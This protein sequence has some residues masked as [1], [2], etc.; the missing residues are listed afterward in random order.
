M[1]SNGKVGGNAGILMRMG[2]DERPVVDSIRRANNALKHHR[3]MVQSLNRVYKA[4]GDDAK[5]L[6]ASYKGL[7]KEIDLMTQKQ[8]LIQRDLAKTTKGT[9]AYE[10]LQTNLQK[11]N[12]QLF[13]LKAR[14]DA[15]AKAM[16]RVNTEGDK[17]RAS[18][19]ATNQLEKQRV[20]LLKLHNK[21]T[22]AAILEQQ[23]YTNAIKQSE[24]IRRTE[25]QTLREMKKQYGASGVAM[26]QQRSKI[27]Q[28]EIEI[29]KYRQAQRQAA[30]A[31]QYMANK[32][33][34][35]QTSLGRTAQL[36]KQNRAFLA[37]LRNGMMS[38][39]AGLT[40][41][42]FPLRRAFTG[43]LGAVVEWEEAF[44]QVRK[45]VN[46]ASEKEFK[47]LDAD[48]MRMSKTI[49]ESATLIAETMGLAA[50]LGVAKENLSGFTEVALQ[51]GVATNMSVDDAASAMA[52]FA[53]VTGMEQ[54]NKNFRKLGSTIVN[55]G[56]NLATQEDEITNYMLRL[57]GT[58]RTVNMAEQ[59]IIALGAAMSSLGINAEAGGSAMSKVMQK[60]N[61]AV[62]DGGE[63]LEEFAKVAGVTGKEFA[64][65]WA[66]DPYKALM[67][68]Q[69]GMKGV[70]DSG[71]NAKKQLEELGIKELRET[72]AVLRLANGYNVMEDAYRHANKGWKE[73]TALSDEAAER[74][75]T[76]GSRIQLF[77]N[78]LFATGRAIG[79][80]L[81]PHL[82]KLMD[83]ITPLL[84]KI[85]ESSDRTKV[86][87]AT[88]AAV[89]IALGPV[90]FV[91]SMLIGSLHSL[92]LGF[93]VLG[94]VL[95]KNPKLMK[96]VTS[97]IVGLSKGSLGGVKSL[98]GLTKASGLLTGGV[99]LLGVAFRFLTGPIGLAI[100]AV[101]ILSKQFVKIYKEVDWAR[102][103]MQ[104]LGSFIVKSLKGAFDAALA[105]IKK[106][107]KG[108]Q[109]LK[110]VIGNFV[111]D[112][113][114]KL[115]KTKFGKFFKDNFKE[116]NEEIRKGKKPMDVL[117]DGVSENTKK[118]LGKYTELVQKSTKKM[119]ELRHGVLSEEDR[120]TIDQYNFYEKRGVEIPK[121]V[122]DAHDKVMEKYGKHAKELSVIYTTMAN[123]SLT[124]LDNKHKDEKTN[125][126]EFF[127]STKAL[128]EKE[129]KEIEKNLQTRQNKQKVET[130][131]LFDEI[132]AIHKKGMAERGYLTDDELKRIE[133]LEVL[134]S[135]KTVQNLA[136]SAQEQEII[137]SRMATNKV[138]V[139][140]EAVEKIVADSE[141]AKDKV[142]KAAE[143]QRDGVIQQAME[144]FEAGTIS[145]EQRD[146]VSK[147]AED[148]YKGV[149]KEADKKHKDVIRIASEQAAE[150]G[151]V[152][153]T[154]TGE[155]LSKWEV[156]WKNTKDG[157]KNFFTGLWYDIKEGWE[158]IKLSAKEFGLSLL[159]L[160]SA[161]SQK[162]TNSV[163]T[164]FT[165]LWEDITRWFTN[166][167]DWVVN[168]FTALGQ[169]I[170]NA[171]KAVWTFIEPAVKLFFKGFE[172]YFK[173]LKYVVEFVFRGI[174]FIIKEVVGFIVGF[175]IEGFSRMY[176]NVKL[177][178][179]LLYTAIKG[180]FNWIKESVMSIVTPTVE[181]VVEKYRWLRNKSN[182]IFT[183]IH[184]FVIGIYTKIKTK[185]SEIVSSIVSFVTNKFN[186]MKTL[187]STIVTTIYTVVRD[188]FINLRDRVLAIVSPFVQKVVG[189]FNLLK[190]K[191]NYVMGI[192]REVITSIWTSIR[193][194]VVGTVTGLR[195]RVVGIFNALKNKVTG[196]VNDTKN[197]VTGGFSEARKTTETILDKMR[198]KVLSIFD[199]IKN[200]ISERIE[201]IKEFIDDLSS[202]VKKSINVVVDGINWV[203]KKIGMSTE[204]PHLHTGTT[205]T[206]DYVTN[207]RINRDTL[208]VVGDR[209]HGNGPNGFRHEMIED[210]KGNLSLTPAEDTVVPLKKGYRV[211]SGKVTHDYLKNK[212]GELPKF[213]S[214]TS[215]G[216]GGLGSWIKS[217]Y[218]KVKDTVGDVMD[219]VK[220]PR[221]L[222]N[223]VLD[224]FGFDNFSTLGGIPKDFAKSGF[225]LLKDKITE[226]FKSALETAE[227]NG[228]Y[229][230]LKKGINFGFA[231]SA[232]AARAAGYPFASPHYGLDLN[233]VYD[234]LYSTIGGTATAKHD[235]SGFGKHIWIKAAKGLE[236]IYGHLSK[237]AFYGTKRV[238]AGDYLGVSGNTGR[239]TGPHLHYEMRKN[240]VPFDPLPWLKNNSK[241]T[242]TA[243]SGVKGLWGGGGDHDHNHD[244]N[245]KEY[246]LL[247]EKVKSSPVTLTMSE[248]DKYSHNR[249]ANY[250][251]PQDRLLAMMNKAINKFNPKNLNSYANGGLV[252]RHQIAE[253]GERNKPE[254]IIPLTKKARA[255][256]LIELAKR[257]VGIDS[258]GN[259]EI[260]NNTVISQGID[261][262]E[263]LDRIE[264]T[265]SQLS[266]AILILAQA[267]VS[268]QIDG[269]EVAKQTYKDINKFSENN[270]RRINK[271]RRD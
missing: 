97:A 198:N 203:G 183:V 98:L 74:Y 256:Q 153:D 270:E 95:K 138:A 194:K 177:T 143:E 36:L 152:V 141:D 258:D 218:G 89:G 9:Q 237:F 86:L 235:N 180:A 133:E 16:S 91:G 49:P 264:N 241:G 227:G 142:I 82:I 135:E 40:I 271:Y 92:S 4:Q 26:D 50:Q 206:T 139:D 170:S 63:D 263:R 187:L 103:A 243:G 10:R 3:S 257:L 18:F 2:I 54:T 145:E 189:L 39:G 174:Y 200:G 196:R 119:T 22:D 73:G 85:Q 168:F 84:K 231:P 261:Y 249:K 162:V 208:A 210:T 216:A 15:V 186:Y 179:S 245:P 134:A 217:T 250:D 72:D 8:R 220:S 75:A 253:I 165:G 125:L 260:E 176:N 154:E 94:G 130:Q 114:E 268:V 68:F 159:V 255:G 78:E 129:Q 136:S 193:T 123:E 238:K 93:S 61:N 110:N 124:Q 147:A 214:G 1:A 120:I 70:I 251:D 221:K 104:N 105:D 178:V 121:K 111:E 34:I 67:L 79:E 14:Q 81:A 24:K 127:K 99:R 155:I 56:N 59:N 240:G 269:R 48:I 87:I 47:Q 23:R 160:L 233:Y 232:A 33:K 266:E 184:D 248:F 5:R 199:K 215:K 197:S 223:K 76:L 102:E 77:K 132:N 150:H 52:R 265:L 109:D 228:S 117:A 226:M 108:W 131:S 29:T 234:K 6:E 156:F 64:E 222:L 53:N 224:M 182:E 252:T 65:L 242:S 239:S 175:V 259:V 172:I 115:G 28:L 80:A 69:K 229:L 151:M 192:V 181:F 13:E 244:A 211:H 207:G 188:K 45:T 113:G 41:V 144:Q 146:K 62:M 37:E 118:I 236:V 31:T 191:L 158:N 225:S 12:S 106:F 190:N 213:S 71:G 60:I 246:E 128:T 122:Q 212:F 43:S 35:L 219:Y 163:T 254:M 55:L 100:T 46:D 247:M 112:I 164:F 27:K 169:T 30:E 83:L 11:V 88:I 204:I 101:L 167:K 51:M 58:G 66:N 149:V 116:M 205:H 148:E 173:T 209:G 262:S 137:I 166:A 25:L 21:H 20:E 38:F 201:T 230:N 96:G 202:A 32:E 19:R 107:I 171:V 140:R 7:S 267:G 157:F 90:L 42:T 44:A 126:E 57:S 185:L 161:T 17:L 195:D